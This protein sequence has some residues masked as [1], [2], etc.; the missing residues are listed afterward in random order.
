ML[1][2]NDFLSCAF[3]SSK[4]WCPISILKIINSKKING[5]TVVCNIPMIVSI[6]VETCI[7]RRFISSVI[8]IFVSG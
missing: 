5:F 6:L 7:I 8:I 2:A 1:L 3:K 4:M